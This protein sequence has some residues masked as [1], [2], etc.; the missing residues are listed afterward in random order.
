[1]FSFQ[2]KH[3][4]SFLLFDAN[5]FLLIVGCFFVLID[6][7]GSDIV[8]YKFLFFVL[9]VILFFGEA[10]EVIF[11]VYQCLLIASQFVLHVLDGVEQSRRRLQSHL[12]GYNISNTKKNKKS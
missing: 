4:P 11:D 12:N 9:M 8:E 6:Y 7:L 3:P 2:L 1:M 5:F 10:G